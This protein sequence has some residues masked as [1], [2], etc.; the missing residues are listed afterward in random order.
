MFLAPDERLTLTLPSP[1]LRNMPSELTVEGGER[2]SPHSWA[3]REVISYEEAFK[4]ELVELHRAI[5]NDHEPLTDG[6]D[7]L[8]DVLLCRS[9][10]QAHMDRAPVENPSR[11]EVGAQTSETAVSEA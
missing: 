9:I 7:G 2:G 5:T 11:V 4:R 10:A 8:H 1:Y 6:R 3:R